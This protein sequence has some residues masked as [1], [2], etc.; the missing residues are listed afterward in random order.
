ML[1]TGP[2]AFSMF[3]PISNPGEKEVS[4]CDTVLQVKRECKS[5]QSYLSKKADN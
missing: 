3:F 5:F 1:N 2:D 4:N